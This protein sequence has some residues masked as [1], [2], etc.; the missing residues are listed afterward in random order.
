[1]SLLVVDDEEV[2]QDVLTSLVQREGWKPFSAHTGEQGLEILEQESIDLV[3]LD[4]MLPKMSGME[5][6][7]QIRQRQPD[8]VVV[9]I[10]AYSS[11]EGAI[12]AMREGAFHYI[13]KPFKNEEVL[14]TIRNGLERRQLAD[15][16]K[17]LKKQLT[18]AKKELKAL[19][20]SFAERLKGAHGEIGAVQAEALALEILHDELRAEVDRRVAAHRQ[21]VV[22]VVENWWAKYRINLREIDEERDE[23]KQRLDTY[24]CELGYAG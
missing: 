16:N 9:I 23:T 4:L 22:T 18:A 12:E 2:L 13:P 3:L 14:L 10:T 5:V 24:L 17:A 11:I 15:E 19:T 1:M 8:Q 21:L 20:L 7:K 6:L